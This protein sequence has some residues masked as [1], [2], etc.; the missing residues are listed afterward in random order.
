MNKIVFGF[1]GLVIIIFIAFAIW[2]LKRKINYKFGYESLVEQTVNKAM[3][4]HVYKCHS[5]S[6]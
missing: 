3:E 4:A 6:K 2:N 1:L 5:I